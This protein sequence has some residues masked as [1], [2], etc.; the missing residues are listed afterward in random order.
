LFVLDVTNVIPA[1]ILKSVSI[2]A[3]LIYVAIL[4]VQGM[5]P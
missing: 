5:K 3:S 1:H 4:I 2:S